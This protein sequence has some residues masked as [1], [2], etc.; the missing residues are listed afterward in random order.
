MYAEGAWVLVSSGTQ[1]QPQIL[2]DPDYLQTIFLFLMAMLKLTAAISSWSN[3]FWYVTY[4]VY[5][6]HSSPPTYQRNL[7]SKPCGANSRCGAFK[8]SCASKISPRAQP[9]VI[10]KEKY[11]TITVGKNLLLW[12]NNSSSDIATFLWLLQLKQHSVGSFLQK[13]LCYRYLPAITWKQLKGNLL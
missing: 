12:S 4:L 9:F 2:L 3:K 6:I 10:R 11:H 5:C 13:Y 1:V 7:L 8:K